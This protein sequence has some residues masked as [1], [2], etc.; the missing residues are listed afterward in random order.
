LG[1]LTIPLTPL[2][3]F[4]NIRHYALIESLK[5]LRNYV[6]VMKSERSDAEYIL[7]GKIAETR[8]ELLKLKDELK[9]LE[10]LRKNTVVQEPALVATQE[11]IESYT[12]VQEEL[13]PP[14]EE[15]VVHKKT[16]K[17]PISYEMKLELIEDDYGHAS[18]ITRGNLFT[19]DGNKKPIVPSW[20]NGRKY[21]PCKGK[22]MRIRNEL[23]K[24]PMTI[25]QM[26]SYTGY[27]L[28]TIKDYVKEMDKQGFFKNT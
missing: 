7:I 2:V 22:M 15:V 5:A 24:G 11:I 18:N 8:K 6:L 1:G 21:D 3:N 13:P 12:G 20:T 9:V 26:S 17:K 27:A 25:R 10:G 16:M 28:D 4:Y 19:A 14:A 23:R